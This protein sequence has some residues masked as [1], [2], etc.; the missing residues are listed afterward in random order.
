[1]RF[2]LS[3]LLTF[4]PLPQQPQG[5]ITANTSTASTATLVQHPH[6]GACTTGTTCAITVA[7]TGTGHLLFAIATGGNNAIQS[8]SG[9]GT[10]ALCTTSECRSG[11][12][13]IAYCLASTSG[14]TT[15]TITFTGS[16]SG[17]AAAVF[18]YSFT[19]SSASY[20]KGGN[21]TLSGQAGSNPATGIALTL[22]GTSD[23]I[24]QSMWG[25][26]VNVTAVSAPYT[27]PADFNGGIGYVGA[28][29]TS[30]GTAP[31]WTMSGAG[32][33]NFASALAIKLNP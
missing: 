26:V 25:N 7:S 24:V 17:A 9:G 1:M 31:S 20:D 30:S 14:A 32:G 11:K 13:D 19:G 6:N 21:N 3:L 23:V 12:S 5:G 33:T 28:I 8:V 22:T 2:L 18:E 4:Y 27:Q 16:N 29:N 15:V 10:W